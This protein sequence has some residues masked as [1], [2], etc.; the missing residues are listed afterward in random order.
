MKT[1]D[2]ISQNQVKGTMLSH[3]CFDKDSS[4]TNARVHLPVAPKCNIQ[5]NFCNRKFD[6]VNESRPGV[7]SGVLTPQQALVYLKEL[8]KKLDNISVVGIAGPGDPFANPEETLKT[9]ELVHA[10]YPAML[11]CLSTNGLNLI[12]YIPLLKQAGVSHVTI[13]VNAVDPTIGKDIYSW[14][15]VGKKVY[16]GE[17]AASILLN[18]QLTAIVMLKKQDITVKINSIILPG[19]NHMHFADIAARVRSLGADVMNCIPVYPNKETVF[20]DM[21]MPGKETIALARNMASDHIKIMSHCARCRAD[22]AGLLGKDLPESMDMIREIAAGPLIPGDNKP[23]VAVATNE[24]LL[25]NLHLGE[26]ER[27][28]IFCQTP[29]GFRFVEDRPTPK[30]G[31]KDYRWIELASLI[32]D[33]RALLTSGVGNN[34]LTI[35]QNAG[36]KVIQMNGLIEEG[37]D[38]V[39][40]N[41][42]LRTVSKAEMFKCGSTC[43]GNAQGCA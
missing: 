28:S 11:I 22:A 26:A 20:C 35:I 2:T 39:Y 9:I 36:I 18:E 32:Q 16:R 34:P 8:H 6:C 42:P 30:S 33:C 7:T 29:E 14:I 40:L 21:E 41:K 12:P 25:V 5:C 13:T 3:P 10:E 37:L 27:L 38:A 4:H 19:V 31:N 15:R 23:Y 43:R 1:I 17:Q 24:G